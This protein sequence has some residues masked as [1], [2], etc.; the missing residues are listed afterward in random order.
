MAAAD[1]EA[2]RLASNEVDRRLALDPLDQGESRGGDY[3]ITFED[4]L[5]VFFEVHR[6]PRTVSVQSVWLS[7]K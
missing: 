6:H 1:P 7:R 5:G 4:P 2:I 3:R